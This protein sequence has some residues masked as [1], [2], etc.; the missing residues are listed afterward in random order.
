MM[1]MAVGGDRWCQ[2]GMMLV[3]HQWFCGYRVGLWGDGVR[4]QDDDIGGR[5]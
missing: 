3:N 2:K 4:V 1:I 5:W